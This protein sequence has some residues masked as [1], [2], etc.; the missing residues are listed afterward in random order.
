MRQRENVT[1]EVASQLQP[2]AEV[3]RVLSPAS[4]HADN[5]K[6]EKEKDGGLIVFYGTLDQQFKQ[7]KWPQNEIK[8]RSPKQNR[9]PQNNPTPPLLFSISETKNHDGERMVPLINSTKKTGY[10]HSHLEV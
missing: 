6:M 9:V 1:L 2:P 5:L 8:H 3:P 10:T 4:V 7:V